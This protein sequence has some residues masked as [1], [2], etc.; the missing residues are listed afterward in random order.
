[1]R[2]MRGVNLRKMSGEN[3]LK[4]GMPEKRFR[5]GVV[6]LMWVC[7]AA[8]RVRAVTGDERNMAGVR[9]LT[10]KSFYLSFKSKSTS[11]VNMQFSHARCVTPPYLRAAF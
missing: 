10:A 3:G 11:I 1:M 9:L 2:T 5:R 8:R 4:A 6:G 7:L